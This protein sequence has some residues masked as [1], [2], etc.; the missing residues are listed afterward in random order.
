MQAA[1]VIDLID[2]L[3]REGRIPALHH[4][5]RMPGTP[6]LAR[7]EYID[8]YRIVF[9]SDLGLNLSSAMRLANDK[10]ATKHVLASHGIPVLA[11]IRAPR[12]LTL[13]EAAD[14]IPFALPWCVKPVHGRFGAGVRRCD[15]ISSALSH[16]A[17]LDV[18]RPGPAMIEP[19]VSL[20]EYRAV[21]ARGEVALAYQ[22]SI[23]AIV[24][25]GEH[26]ARW[27]LDRLR[28]AATRTSGNESYQTR[29][30]AAAGIQSNEVVAEG[31]TVP[32]AETANL[33]AGAIATDVLHQ[34]HPSFLVMCRDVAGAIGLDYCGIDLAIADIGDPASQH[35]IHE[36]N[37]APSVLHFH[38]S[39]D[40]AARQVENMLVDLV[41]NRAHPID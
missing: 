40:E 35:F 36:V 38:A 13:V 9:G 10:L 20:P 3:R 31:V 15:D 23:P 19:W 6:H 7:L 18:G 26:T 29:V 16:V 28:L 12:S 30:L 2:R 37:A 25:D 8:G 24:G 33:S 1:R 27:L 34:I 14:L 22:R 32:L 4:V 21:V 39:G 5:V 41:G 11:G 17:H